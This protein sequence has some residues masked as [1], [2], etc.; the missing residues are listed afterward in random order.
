[1]IL[2][3]RLIKMIAPLKWTMCISACSG[4]IGHLCA[5]AIM[6]LGA[7]LLCAAAGFD[8]GVSQGALLAAL[9][10]CAVLRGVF[11]YVEQY[12]GHDVAFRLLAL[13]R[14]RIFLALRRLAPAKLVDR[15]SG[16]LNAAIIADVEL[17]EVF[18]AHT[19]SP[20]IIAIVVSIAML[21]YT[22][23]FGWIFPALAF[24]FYT[25]TALLSYITSKRT[26]SLHGKAYRRHFSESSSHLLD[27]IRGLKE[28]LIFRRQKERLQEINERGERLNKDLDK[29]RVLKSIAVAWPEM[30]I[31]LA[32]M[33]TLAVAVSIELPV[34]RTIVL[35]MTIAS[36]FGPITALSALTVD[37]ANTFAAAERI[38]HI[39]D[40]KPTVTDD[41][42]VEL[43]T[44][45]GSAGF[46]QVGFQY[47]GTHS[48]VLSQFT[49]P[50]GAG[51]K[52][53]LI[54]PSGCGKST[55]LR[56]LLRYFNCQEGRIQLSG[57]NV[58]ALSL[59]ALRS[60]VA[61]L[62]QDTFLFDESI[63]Y[64]I[65]LGNPQASEDEIRTAARR[66]MID[67]FIEALPNGYETRVGELGDR[68]SGGERQ[69]IGIARVLLSNAS[70]LVL[71]EPTSNLDVLNEQGILSILR[72]EC[73]DRTV[74]MVSHRPS[75]VQW[76]DI[77]Y[78]LEPAAVVYAGSRN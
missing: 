43:D 65:R 44:P 36:S 75:A 1:M 78:K 16:D 24:C 14:E 22:A 73:A 17:I 77:V 25:L 9:I 56:L 51:R 28:I 13:L 72:K 74:I 62:T 45:D 5:I 60:H 71:D 70:I 37:L 11:R 38:F 66:A 32:S 53:A 76:A 50:V 6:T 49:L 26:S 59:T 61:M 18:F 64:N 63:A 40:E 2:A 29:L 31:A 34:D 30:L 67:S 57:T 54:G 41:G 42:W 4:I 27:S 12:T 21:A 48:P 52:I 23:Q 46:E 69:R 68:L 58:R 47:P 35:T 19:V 3:K 55:A 10:A 15:H 20:I 7:M 8:T 39:L 33:T